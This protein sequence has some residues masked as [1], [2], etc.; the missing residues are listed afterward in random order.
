MTQEERKEA[1]AIEAKI[2]ELRAEIEKLYTRLAELEGEENTDIRNKE[3]FHQKM[4]FKGVG[5]GKVHPMDLDGTLD[6]TGNGLLVLEGKYKDAPL[7]KGQRYYFEKV[8]RCIRD[9]KVFIGAVVE[10]DEPRKDYHL[11][12]CRVREIYAKHNRRY[13]WAR[14]LEGMSGRH[15]MDWVYDKYV[16]E[17]ILRKE[18]VLCLR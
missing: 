10:H 13:T 12:D 7:E 4:L 11:A 18:D 14:N 5:R 8:A 2:E 17:R 1:E 3:H 6:L 16:D 15:F 9:D